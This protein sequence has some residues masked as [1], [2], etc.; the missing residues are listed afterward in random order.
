MSLAGKT[1][2]STGKYVFVS[3]AFGGGGMKI[4]NGSGSR[5]WTGKMSGIS[6]R[7]LSRLR[8]S[9]SYKITSVIGP[10][11]EKFPS[12]KKSF[13]SI[14]FGFPSWCTP[15]KH[16]NPQLCPR[17]RSSRF[18]RFPERRSRNRSESIFPEIG[19]GMTPLRHLLKS[20][21]SQ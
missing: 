8:S 13:T 21:K 20:F 16:T 4:Q 17:R 2:F 12:W 1:D 7:S 10:S 3:A 18:D 5:L 15:D 14:Q 6:L 11:R 19:S 9:S